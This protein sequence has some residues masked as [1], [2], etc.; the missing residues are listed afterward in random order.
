MKN[1][2]PLPSDV[3]IERSIIASMI[4]EP[5]P[6]I[7]KIIDKGIVQDTFHDDK[8]KILFKIIS[9]MYVKKGMI[10]DVFTVLNELTLI[11]CNSID[12]FYLIELTT[13]I[14]TVAYIDEWCRVV[15]KLHGARYLLF[16]AEEACYNIRHDMPI[17]D[18]ISSITKHAT[19]A[20][21]LVVN[22]R[23][24][25]TKDK[26]CNT[27]QFIQEQNSGDSRYYVPFCLPGLDDLVK[28][29]KKEVMILGAD[30]NVGKTGLIVSIMVARIEKGIKTA[31]FCAESTHQKIIQRLMCIR[32]GLT[33]S[34]IEG[35]TGHQEIQRFKEAAEWLNDNRQY[36]DIFGKGDYE[37][38]I[39][40]IRRKVMR[41]QDDTGGQL[42]AIDIDY[43]QNHKPYKAFRG[44]GEERISEAMLDCNYL[45]AEANVAG[46][47]LS[48]FNRDKE[49]LA[50]NKPPNVADLKYASTIEQEADLICFLHR[51]KNLAGP[52]VNVQ[53]YDEKHR[54]D[55][56]LYTNLE[57]NTMLGAFAGVA[58]RYGQSDRPNKF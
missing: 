45:F 36:F 32:S 38:T 13:C 43:I 17:D 15:K 25:T 12:E 34:Q 2:K 46:C 20:S 58:H 57:M 30:A 47:I 10:P 23:E 52:A 14:A 50:K 5:R 9:E 29:G 16:R 42:Q 54:G 40:G 35:L 4:I 7:D 33:K 8:C 6:C 44:S 48:Q 18:I 28:H 56:R 24:E 1:D 39:E 27:V 41:I 21:E 55:T 53:F 22:K 11:N 37:N 3:N 31:I 49:R 26:I 19:T 51:D